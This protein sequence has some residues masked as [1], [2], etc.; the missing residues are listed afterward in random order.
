MTPLPFDF[1]KN[2]EDK[3][4]AKAIHG[5]VMEVLETEPGKHPEMSKRLHVA[6]RAALSG[7]MYSL[8]QVAGLALEFDDNIFNQQVVNKAV[9]KLLIDKG[10]TNADEYHQKLIEVTETIGG[11]TVGKS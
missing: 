7:A 6:L 9:V 10:I 2:V 11:E 8:E 5:V 4:G 3:E 1:L